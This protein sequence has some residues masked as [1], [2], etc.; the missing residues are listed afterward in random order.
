[1]LTRDNP[2]SI[3]LDPY[4]TTHDLNTRPCPDNT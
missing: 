2:Y 3:K 1:M 4:S